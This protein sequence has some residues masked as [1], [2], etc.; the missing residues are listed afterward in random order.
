MAVSEGRARDLARGSLPGFSGV[1]AVVADK[2]KEGMAPLVAHLQACIDT[3][4]VVY[5]CMDALATAVEGD[6]SVAAAAVAAGAPEALVA[7]IQRHKWSERTVEACIRAGTALAP[8]AAAE[9]TA[10]GLLAALVVAMTASDSSYA[11]Q[12]TAVRLLLVLTSAHP[13][14]LRASLDAG[15][16]EA[17]RTAIDSNPDDGQLQWRG[18]NLLD[19]LK[20]GQGEEVRERALRRSFS[21][22]LRRK[23]SR[24]QMGGSFV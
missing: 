23:D 14:A 2:A 12:S 3:E 1:S 7:V 24:A 6:A 5:W 19:A 18:M 4:E 16:P 20:P 8:F 11:V 22:F 15:V 9:C 10:A 17:V 13:P 21:S